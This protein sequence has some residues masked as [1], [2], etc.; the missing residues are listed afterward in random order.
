MRF[1]VWDILLYTSAL[2]KLSG[3]GISTVSLFLV[4][5]LRASCLRAM[6]KASRPGTTQKLKSSPRLFLKVPN[7]IYTIKEPKALFG[8]PFSGTP[9][10][11]LLVKSHTLRSLGKT[12]NS[13]TRPLIEFSIIC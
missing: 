1:R 12:G 5:M 2:F 3:P 10:P 4:G 6:P 9:P 11:I 13:R 8:D 7:H